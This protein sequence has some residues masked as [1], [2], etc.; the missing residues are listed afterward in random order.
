M[1]SGFTAN[2]LLALGAAPAMVDIPDE[3]GP[4]ASV[5]SG[6]LINLGTP[7]EPTPSAV[8]RAREPDFR[9]ELRRSRGAYAWVAH[10][11]VS[12]SLLVVTPVVIGAATSLYASEIGRAHV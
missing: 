9:V 12:V 8:R 5:A 3:A 6:V 10:A 1:V 11:A 7:D 4:F 2:V